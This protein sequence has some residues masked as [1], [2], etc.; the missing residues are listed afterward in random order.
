MSIIFQL[1]SAEDL[2]KLDVEDLHHLREEVLR[3]LGRSKPFIQNS[4]GGK[5][6]ELNS[7]LL[8]LRRIN[9]ILNNINL[10][11]S[12]T[13]IQNCPP[14]QVNDRLAE[15]KKRVTEIQESLDDL[16]GRLYLNLTEKTAFD[17]GDTIKDEKRSKGMLR[18]RFNEVA[19]QLDASSQDFN[20]Q[21]LINGP[22]YPKETREELILRWAISCELNHIVFYER[23]DKVKETA[24]KFL[25]DMLVNKEQERNPS[26][27]FQEPEITKI[28]TL[29]PSDSIYSP[30]NPRHPLYRQY[31]VKAPESGK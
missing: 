16:T 11:D 22:V 14:N 1:F 8:S 30:Y 24:D 21:N 18:K 10:Q 5:R 25:G 12:E 13:D 7:T 27:Q 19:H 28:R 29:K 2:K 17:A 6:D 15:L 31:N 20:Y 4:D 9:T 23:L 3:A 26:K